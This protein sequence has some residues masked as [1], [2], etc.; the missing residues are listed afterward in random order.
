MI[1]IVDSVQYTAEKFHQTTKQNYKEIL[2]ILD[3]LVKLVD[4]KLKQTDLINFAI[5]PSK[6][7]RQDGQEE[8]DSQT[9]EVK[10]E[11]FNNP[12]FI[13]EFRQSIQPYQTLIPNDINLFLK[14]NNLQQLNS[15]SESNDTRFANLKTKIESLENSLK[16]NST[17]ESKQNLKMKNDDLN[18]NNK[19]IT[20]LKSGLDST[21][22]LILEVNEFIDKLGISTNDE[23]H[24]QTLNIEEIYSSNLMFQEV[25]NIF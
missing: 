2:L 6:I 23:N 10:L 22:N 16:K 21:N 18:I 24:R 11:I 8:F 17:N 9:N 25:I 15:N 12:D 5:I 1:N 13:R 20:E 14:A 4:Y 7:K 19:F 3:E